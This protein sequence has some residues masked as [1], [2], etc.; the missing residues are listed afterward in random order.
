M[1][2]NSGGGSS[3]G[4]GKWRSKIVMLEK[5]VRNQRRQLLVFNTAAKPGLDNEESDGSDTSE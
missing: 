4:H 2:S 5:K 3:N 1:K